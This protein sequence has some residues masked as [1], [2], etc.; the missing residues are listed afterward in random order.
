MYIVLHTPNRPDWEL[1][2]IIIEVLVYQK[3]GKKNWLVSQ[4]SSGYIFIQVLK[5]RL[6]TDIKIT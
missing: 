2:W 4:R 5:S 1:N 3:K 6:L